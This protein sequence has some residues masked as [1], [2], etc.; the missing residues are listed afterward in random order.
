MTASDFGSSVFAEW[1]KS[2]GQHW[3][4]YTT[5][6]YVKGLG[7]GTLPKEKFVHYLIQDYVFLVHFSRAW[8]L[9]AVKSNT[10]DEMKT[11]AGTVDA[12]VNHE[13]QLHVESC[14]KEG[15][16][17]TQLFEAVEAPENM[18]YTRFVM[19]A[20]LSGDFLDLMA[21]LAPCVFGYGEIGNN[22]AETGASDN[23]YQDWIDTYSGADYQEVCTTVATMIDTAAKARLGED[24]EANPRWHSLC[25][26]FTKATRLEVGFWEMAMRGHP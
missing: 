18:A 12:L 8:A 19:D 15:I 24:F 22:L 23:P 21:A 3:S 25:E 14:A 10:L 2:A 16:S 7:D 4:D 5:H 6:A 26:T 20:G 9:A 17:E 13:M 1:R 11:A